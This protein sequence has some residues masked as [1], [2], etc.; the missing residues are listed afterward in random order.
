MYRRRP[1]RSPWQTAMPLAQ[2]CRAAPHTLPCASIPRRRRWW[3]YIVV[4]RTW[5]GQPCR[6]FLPP[7]SHAPSSSRG[8][9][10]RPFA[11]ASSGIAPRAQP[12]SRRAVGGAWSLQAA[13]WS[14]PPTRSTLPRP[15]RRPVSPQ[16]LTRRLL[17]LRC[18]VSLAIETR[19]SPSCSF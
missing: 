2:A 17:L 9:H 7:D 10:P 18:N 4:S 3:Q 5:H 8:G 14:S 6:P 16:H 1:L 11:P 15:A 12:L 19:C 13:T